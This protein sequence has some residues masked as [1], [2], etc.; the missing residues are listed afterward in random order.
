MTGAPAPSPVEEELKR[1]SVSASLQS[2]LQ[3]VAREYLRSPGSVTT[4]HVTYK[5]LSVLYHSLDLSGPIDG[6]WGAWGQWSS[7]SK[8]CEGGT[9][10]RIRMCQSSTSAS[11]QGIPSESRICNNHPCKIQYLSVLFHCLDLLGPVDGSWGSWAVW[12]ACSRSCGGGTE[13][14]RR[15]CDSPAPAQG[16]T[17]C[18]GDQHQE[19]QCNTEICPLPG[20]QLFYFSNHCY[21]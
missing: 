19:R 12:S 9:E 8:S 21:L 18:Q 15:L 13:T 4:T 2:L 6:T 14:R 20:N 3:P 17:D 11:C 16:G 10:V 1:D 5:Y 7:C